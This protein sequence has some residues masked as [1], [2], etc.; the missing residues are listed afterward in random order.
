MSMPI[1]FH[2]NKRMLDFANA[3]VGV[4]FSNILSKISDKICF[5]C[6]KTLTE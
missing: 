2:R 6:A 5:W 3:A 4:L 1:N